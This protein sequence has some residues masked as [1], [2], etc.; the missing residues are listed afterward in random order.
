MGSGD[1]K[2][3]K[4]E[5]KEEVS[6]GASTKVKEEETGGDEIPTGELPPSLLDCIQARFAHEGRGSFSR[7][8]VAGQVTDKF[9]NGESLMDL[10]VYL[11][12]QS[13]NCTIT[14]FGLQQA[15]SCA[16]LVECLPDSV[17]SFLRGLLQLTTVNNLRVISSS[18]DVGV[19]YF[20]PFQIVSVTLQKEGEIDLEVDSGDLTTAGSDVYVRLLQIGQ[21]MKEGSEKSYSKF[22][23]IHSSKLP[24]NERVVALSNC[25]GFFTVT[26]YLKVF[27]D[28]VHLVLESDLVWPMEK[29]LE[30]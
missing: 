15:Q 29:P 24:S 27:S 4:E 26:E 19:Q 14:G 2:S 22:S 7:L 18:E 30:Y 28:P 13:E 12:E 23:T 5:E 8:L 25:D 11:N 1:G 10:I 20:L 6:G 16:I 21:H 17:P 9:G 3:K